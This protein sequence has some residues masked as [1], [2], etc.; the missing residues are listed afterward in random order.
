MDTNKKINSIN[1]SKAGIMIT[2]FICALLVLDRVT[3]FFAQT[4]LMGTDGIVIIK[5]I[6]RLQYLENRGAAFGMLQNKQIFSGSLLL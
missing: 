5:N 3:K 6:L 1:N 2:A 4:F